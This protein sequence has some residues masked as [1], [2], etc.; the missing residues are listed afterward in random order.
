MESR[1]HVLENRVRLP[2]Y[3]H[4][5]IGGGFVRSETIP[6]RGRTVLFS[7]QKTFN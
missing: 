3:K 2:A 7:L 5:M 4:D 1:V 6:M